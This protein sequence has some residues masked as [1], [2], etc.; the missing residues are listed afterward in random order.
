MM[1]STTLG[2]RFRS[3]WQRAPVTAGWR[4][5]HNLVWFLHGGW[6]LIATSGRAS[7]F[8]GPGGVLTPLGD[9]FWPRVLSG[10]TVYSPFPLDGIHTY[11]YIPDVAAG[12]A[13]LGCAER[14]VYGRPWMLPCAP[15]GTLRELVVRLAT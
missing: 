8:Y 1:F 11:H 15:A 13:T 2:W 10:R 12:L 4:L 7:D 3:G 6:L 5:G 14:D 9:F